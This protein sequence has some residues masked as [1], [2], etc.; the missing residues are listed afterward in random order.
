[1]NK[2]IMSGFGG[3]KVSG[4]DWVMPVVMLGALG[5]GGY[6]LLQMLKT[7]TPGAGITA[8]NNAVTTTSAATA[9]SSLA[10]A[11]AKGIAQSIDDT[12]LNGYVTAITN[13]ITPVSSFPLD[14]DTA[15]T[16]Q[17][18]IVQMNTS[19]DWF[20]LVQLFGTK[21]YNAGGS[22]SLCSWFAIGCNSADLPG[23]LKATMPQSNINTINSYFA[24]T[25]GDVS[26][27]I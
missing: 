14:S 1:M 5:V 17:N 3:S 10:A 21:N 9:A 27:S 11:Q 6:F 2:S 26:I 25:F 4:N 16:I 19:A 18:I 23:M 13:T 20:R 15:M 8:N 7:S 24:S 22:Q 12:T